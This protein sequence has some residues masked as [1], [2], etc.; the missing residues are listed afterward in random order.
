MR[1]LEVKIRQITW[2]INQSFKPTTYDLVEFMGN[3]YYI[4]SSLTGEGVWNLYLKV[5]KEPNHRF[6]RTNE[7][8]LIH[9]FG[10]FVR[11]FKE[12]MFFQ[13]SS[14][15]SIDCRNPIGTRLS[16]LSSDNIRFHRHY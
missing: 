9:S 13:W 1:K 2:S 11:V 15:Q 7:L 10:R 12:H 8:K 3:K 14:W 6:I 5:S 16:Y 4:K